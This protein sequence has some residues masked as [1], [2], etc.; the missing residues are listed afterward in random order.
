MNQSVCDISPEG[1]DGHA[2]VGV[3]GILLPENARSDGCAAVE[4]GH[5]V[6][7]GRKVEAYVVFKVFHLVAPFH[8]HLDTPVVGRA[9]VGVGV[10]VVA[11]VF[12]HGSCQEHVFGGLV[13]IL[14]A[15]H[16]PVVEE[17]RVESHVR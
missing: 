12:R 8:V 9:D 17:C 14:E 7:D 16:E 1:S 2:L 5:S 11:H 13:V 6:A 10:V 15:E 4:L 3:G